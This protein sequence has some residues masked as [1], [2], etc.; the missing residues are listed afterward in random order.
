MTTHLLNRKCQPLSGSPMAEREVHDHLA[1]VSGWHL[2]D[3]AIEKTFSF[4]NY[5]ET[6]A[7]VNALAWVAHTEDH[8]PD[9]AVSYNRCVVRF[10][11]HSVGGISINDFICAAKADALVAFV[12]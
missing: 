4:K 2:D 3:G 6:M 11:T 10:N 7:F 12:G 1:Q 8:H 9:L 5:H